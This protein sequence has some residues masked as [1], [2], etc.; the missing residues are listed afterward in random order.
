MLKKTS[1]EETESESAELSNNRNPTVVK[2]DAIEAAENEDMPR[3]QATRTSVF[4]STL[5]FKGE[6]SADEEILIEGTVEGTIAHHSKNVIIG[7]QGR[8]S[9]LIH[10]NS[11]TIH[12]QVDGDIHGDVM[13]VLT[14]GCQVNGKIFCPR[15]VMEDGAKFD[16]TIQMK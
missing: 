8:V 7:K 3:D 15:V 13:V 9:A 2:T 1:Y 12:G 11:I 6:L 10:A 14:A 4:G 16:G 5:V